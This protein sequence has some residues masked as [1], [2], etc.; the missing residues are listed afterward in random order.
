MKKKD[1]SHAAFGRWC[2]YLNDLYCWVR[3]YFNKTKAKA[4][5]TADKY[6][7]ACCDGI[8]GENESVGVDDITWIP[9]D[10]EGV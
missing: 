2:Q 5:Q 6:L 7:S 1:L 9:G 8:F 3:D 10:M 4:F